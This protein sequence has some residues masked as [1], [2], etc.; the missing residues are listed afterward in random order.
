MTG[1]APIFHSVMLA[2]MKRARG[3]LPIGDD[4]AIVD[5][6]RD[7]PVAPVTKAAESRR[8]PSLR[9]TNPPNGATYLIDPTLR[10]SYQQLHL[11]ATSDVVWHVDGRKVDAEWTLVAGTHTIVAADRSGHRDSVKIFVK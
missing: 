9:V 5:V 7:L 8:T 10:S 4:R 6:P 2:A 1:A 3:T 11:R